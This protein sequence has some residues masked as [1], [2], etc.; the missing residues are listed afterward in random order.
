MSERGRERDCLCVRER[1]RLIENLRER[2]RVCARKKG[3]EGGNV[4]ETEPER[5]GNKKKVRKRI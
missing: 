5:R 4:R 1:E 3:R 2:R